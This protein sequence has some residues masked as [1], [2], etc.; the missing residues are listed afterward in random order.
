MF[1]HQLRYEVVGLESKFFWLPFAQQIS[2]LVQF[3]WLGAKILAFSSSVFLGQIT[4]LY[5]IVNLKKLC[6]M[7]NASIC[8]AYILTEILVKENGAFSG[9]SSLGVRGQ[10]QA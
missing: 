4:G 3:E 5:S 1:E 9:L 10:Q 2:F 6:S 8:T 7:I